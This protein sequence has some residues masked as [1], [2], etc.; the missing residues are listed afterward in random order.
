MYMRDVFLFMGN[1]R[2]KNLL[3]YCV[4]ISQSSHIVNIYV[5]Y[6]A[7]NIMYIHIMIPFHFYTYYVWVF[8]CP[9]YIYIYIYIYAL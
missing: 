5:F 9:N 1:P 7:S 8:V 4:T 6:L 3:I 2:I